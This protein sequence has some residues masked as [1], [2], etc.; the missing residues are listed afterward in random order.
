[1]HLCVPM[2]ITHLSGIV[3]MAVNMSLK[4]VIQGLGIREHKSYHMDL[5]WACFPISDSEQMKISGEKYK[6]WT[7]IQVT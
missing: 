6:H 3:F 2:N 5:I 1:M 7:K 4:Y